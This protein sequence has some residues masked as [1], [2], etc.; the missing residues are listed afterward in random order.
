MKSCRHCGS[1]EPD[2]VYRCSMCERPLPIE[3]PGEIALKKAALTVVVPIFVWV[4][5][6]RVLGV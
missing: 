1:V 3:W 5:M 6:T 2:D 4:V